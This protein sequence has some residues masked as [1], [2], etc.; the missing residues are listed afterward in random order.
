MPRAQ[1][2]DNLNVTRLLRSRLHRPSCL[3]DTLVRTGRGSHWQLQHSDTDP[4]RHRPLGGHPPLGA[5]LYPRS[6]SNKLYINTIGAGDDVRTTP[7][8]TPRPNRGSANPQSRIL[9]HLL[10]HLPTLLHLCMYHGVLSCVC[11]C[12]CVQVSSRAFQRCVFL[13]S[14]CPPGQCARVSLLASVF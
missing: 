6:S 7:R 8:T 4:T 2:R 9:E 5:Q 11:V 10:S 14:A 13:F 12:V 1:M 3:E